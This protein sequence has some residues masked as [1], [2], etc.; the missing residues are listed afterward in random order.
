MEKKEFTP[1]ALNSKHETFVVHV[2]SLSFTPLDVHH[3]RRPQI[4]SLIAKKALTKVPDEYIHFA[5]MFSADLASKLS[6]YTEINDHALELVDGQLSSY[7][8][9]Y[10]LGS[11]ELKILKAYIKTNIANRFIGPSKSP[12]SNPIMFDQ[13]QNRFF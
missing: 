9:I 13:K 10:S 1:A 3:S 4:S 6:E 11:V 8:P 5:D 12:A 7:G 2:A